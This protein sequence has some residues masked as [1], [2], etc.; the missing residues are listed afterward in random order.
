ME[1]DVSDSLHC[2]DLLQSIIKNIQS[3]FT[4]TIYTVQSFVVAHVAHIANPGFKAVCIACI[5]YCILSFEG[6]MIDPYMHV[7]KQNTEY[8]T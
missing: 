8:R 3:D 4:V 7:Y 1:S 5:A 6:N 2:F